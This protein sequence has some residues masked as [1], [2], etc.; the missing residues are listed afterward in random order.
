MTANV[1]VSESQKTFDPDG[2]ERCDGRGQIQDD[3]SSAGRSGQMKLVVVFAQR[4]ATR[5]GRLPGVVFD[6]EDNL[7]GPSSRCSANTCPSSWYFLP[8]RSSFK[9]PDLRSEDSSLDP[10]TSRRWIPPQ[11]ARRLTA[12]LTGPTKVIWA[13]A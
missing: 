1:P 6:V 9:W 4:Y 10:T 3:A 12:S 2:P 11:G 7:L 8:F 13:E 5:L